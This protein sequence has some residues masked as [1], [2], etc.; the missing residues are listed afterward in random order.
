MGNFHITK[1]NYYILEAAGS[2]KLL[3]NNIM[4]L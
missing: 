2:N 4:Q 3:K 1:K